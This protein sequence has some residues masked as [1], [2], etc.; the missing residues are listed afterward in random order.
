MKIISGGQFGADLGALEGAKL[1]GLSTGGTAPQFYMTEN[2]AQKELLQAYGLVEGGFD[3]RIYPMRTMKNVDDADATVAI[4]WG[5]SVGTSK[6]IGYAMT[7]KWQHPP[8]FA[9]TKYKPILVI[10]THDLQQAAWELAAFYLNKKYEVLNFAGHR[11]SSQPGI[12]KFVRE[13]VIKT[14]KQ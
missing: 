6:T 14:F 10:T 5:E 12:Q 3:P 11:E 2:R 13:L 1:V 4:M 7:H 9:T 8:V